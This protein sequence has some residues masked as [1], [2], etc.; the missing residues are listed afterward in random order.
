MKTSGHA[1]SHFK[2]PRFAAFLLAFALMPAALAGSRSSANYTV[3]ADTNDAGGLRATSAGYSNSGSVG[4]VAGSSAV[5]TYTLASGYVAQIASGGPVPV[6]T[7]SLTA[8]GTYNTPISIYQITATNSPTSYDATGL[9]SGLVVNTSTGAI[10]GTPTAAGGP[11]NVTLSA[12]NA[13][14]TGTATLVFTIAKATQT[15]TFTG[16][17]NQPFSPVPITLSATASSGLTVSFS[18]LSG[19][20]SVVGTSL[21]LTGPGTVVIRAS[22]PGD[23]N[24]SATPVV[25]RNLVVSA[26]SPRDFNGDGKADILWENTTSG[27]RYI[28]FMNGSTIT[29]ALNLGVISTDWRIGG[30][31]D[32]NGDGKADILWEN[33]VSGDRYIWFMNGSTI[34]SA[35]DLGIISTDWRI[36]GTGDFNGDGKADI[37]WENTVTGDRYIW[38]MNGSTITSA[39]DLGII[40]TDWRSAN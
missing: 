11:T 1:P 18:V 26:A 38:F 31:G 24:Y 21:T 30:V 6:I 20:A 2:S 17:A 12:T 37:L 32:F 19:P 40:S 25:D 28:W 27:D 3:A 14:G 23:S 29:S 16:P 33:T 8:S 5:G 34:T 15:I 10:T 7:S 9:P 36:S 39:V 4:N 35:V 13:S 22:Q